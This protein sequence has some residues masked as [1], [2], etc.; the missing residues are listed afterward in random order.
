MKKAPISYCIIVK[1]EPLLENCL[2]S[3]RDHVEE[4]VIIDTGSTDG[5]SIEIAK[6]Y[7]D[8]FES[9]SGCNDE[10]GLISDFANARQKSFDLATQQ[11]VG[12]L[13][14]DDELQGAENL[15]Q[16]TN[17]YQDDN[18]ILMLPYEYAYNEFGECICLHYRER[19]VRNKNKFHWV[20]PVHEVLVPN[21]DV[22]PQFHI[23]ETVV[24]KHKR[25]F[26]NKVPEPGRNLRILRKYYE[27]VGDT[28]A[29]QLYYLGLECYNAGLVA[30]A[31][32]HFIKYIDISGWDDERAMACMKLIEIYQSRGDYESG[33]K[34][35]FKIVALKETWSEGYFAL[36]KMF[37]FLAL[38][39]DVNERRHWERCVNFI[40]IGLSL[41]PT[42]TLL[43]IN[44]V[45]RDVEIH[46]YY[47]MGLNKLGDVKGALESVNM[48]L[49][50]Q[51]TDQP[52]L[53]NKK[54]YESY[55]IKQDI[56]NSINKLKEMGELNDNSINELLTL[57][58]RSIKQNDWN[59]PNDWDLDGLPLQLN[60]D[61]LKA[62]V[63]MLWKQF[64]LQDKVAPAIRFLNSTGELLEPTQIN[65]IL[66]VTKKYL[67]EQNT[68]LG[69]TGPNCIDFSDEKL[70]EINNNKLDIVMFAGNGVE[71]WTPDT[72]KQ[73]GIGGSELMLLEMAKRF[74][75]LGHKV[76]V[77]S[78]CGDA[79]GYYDGVQYQ[80]TEKFQDLTCDVL[81]V[82]RRA[83]MLAD[84]YNIKAKLKLLWLHDICAVNGEN[85]YLLKADR[86]L[87][88]SEWHKNNV[89]RVHNLH[90]DQVIVTRNGIDLERFKK[91]INRDKFK[92]INS[93]SPDRSW[94]ILLECWQYIKAQVP[95]AELHLYYGFKNW[96]YSAPSYPGQ[97]DLINS[98]KSKITEMKHLGVHY[99]GR[100][101]QQQLASDMLSSGVWAYPTWFTE[102]SC[103]IAG[104]LIFTKN[105]MKKIEDIEVNDLVLTHKGRFR[106]VTKLIE[107]EYDGK[108]YN[109][110]KRKDFNPI[111]LTEE[112]PLLTATFH[113]RS[114]SKGNR[115]YSNKNLN[116]KWETPE[117]LIPKQNYLLSPK[118]EFGDLTKLKFSDYV[119]LP[120][121]E[122]NKIGPIKKHS[123]YKYIDNEINITEEFMYMLGLFAAEGCATSKRGK[124]K[125]RYGAITFAMHLKEIEKAKRVINYFE[126]GK[127]TQTSENGISVNLHHSVWAKFLASQIG[128]G[129]NKKIPAFI[130]DCSKE[131]QY[132]FIL[133]MFEGDGCIKT[134]NDHNNANKKY[135]IANYTSISP[136]LIY[137]ISQLLSNQGIYGSLNYSSKRK[138]YNLDWSVESKMPQHKNLD[139]GFATRIT[140]INS[141]N[142]SGTVYNFEV[143]E[144]ES[145]VTDRT[146]VHNCLSAMEAQAAGLRL[147]TSSIAAL[148]E[149]VNNRGILINGDWTTLEYKIQFMNSVIEAL[150]K[151]DN[152]DRLILQQ[153]AK[154]NFGIDDL[155]KSW[156][157]MFYNLI[158]EMKTNPI[159]PYKPTTPY[160]DGGRGYHDGDTRVR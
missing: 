135:K 10:N 63:V 154:D 141:K 116:I 85:E 14:A 138:A 98:L 46:R 131:M 41:P 73:T 129:I 160:M 109:I 32:A 4:I 55:L 16:L 47:N 42:K 147:V 58:D 66:D 35:A 110:K 107:K 123:N 8:I 108:L 102:T 143:E 118:M 106:P 67:L 19:L 7:A 12:W 68:K 150:R 30:E 93:S 64:M 9:Y 88:L 133:G 72:V 48:A 139:E 111:I 151:E 101:N 53:L 34:W 90:S 20:N 104:S 54:V 97:V 37:Y 100:V 114:D 27:K 80:L 26:S 142:Y 5:T 84:Q 62:S 29:R 148:N 105:G 77:Y 74:A 127:V 136:S 124:Q 56:T 36:G 113:K 94:P 60:D 24:Y 61:Q 79:E 57:C 122:N 157:K 83:D 140:A 86:I 91:E 39:A 137:G 81:V 96:E 18:T 1:N 125:D 33:V 17:H 38:K 152:S 44:P 25:Q 28:D 126:C 15:L 159:V 95:E 51:P 43:F 71:A 22:Q 2:L 45:D 121:D 103:Q 155:A 40:R 75:K 6:K 49:S 149:T 3:I 112:H 145:Y 144:D 158:E 92:V 82:S 76:R 21:K 132:A 70:V 13:D 128:T 130:W 156:D 99:H 69:F 146:I 65:D 11:W 52:L 31:E 115:V 23:E 153:Y 134:T 59:I 117:N 89:I 50:K 78:S 87:V 120:I 119:D